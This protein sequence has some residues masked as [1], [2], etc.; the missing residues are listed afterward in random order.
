MIATEGE[1]L[2][3]SS[4]SSDS[5]LDNIYQSTYDQVNGLFMQALEASTFSPEAYKLISDSQQAIH[6]LPDIASQI[7]EKK[8]E[9]E[10]N[11]L[12]ANQFILESQDLLAKANLVL[13]NDSDA[14][15]DSVYKARFLPLIVG[16][17]LSLLFLFFAL[18]MG[19][20]FRRK[21]VQSIG[22]LL[23]ATKAVTSGKLETRA[24]I[25]EADEFG[26][27]ADS[28][29][30]MTT[31]LNE[32]TVSK[33]FVENIL[34]SMLDCVFVL[35]T[36]GTILR[37]NRM[38]SEIF[39]YSNEELLSSHVQ[40]ILGEDFRLGNSSMN[41]ETKA[42]AKSGKV[43]PIY[44][45][46]SL[47]ENQQELRVCVIKD[48][49]EQK[50]FENELR[51]RNL[52]LANSNRELEAFS[53]SVSH[54]LRSPLRGI[55]GFSQALT[56]DYADKL[57]EEAKSYLTRI[58]AGVQR[59]G[60]LIDDILNLA[61]LSRANMTVKPVDL[62]TL[63]RTV[64]SELLESDPKRE[65]DFKIQDGITANADPIL[66]RVAVENLIGNAW[67][68]T[69]KKT[70]A[71]IEFGVT[72]RNGKTAYYIKD[73]GAGFDM[74]YSEKLFVPFQRLHEVAQFPGSGV[75]LASVQ[76]VIHRHGGNI[77]AEGLVEQGATFYFTL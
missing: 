5:K 26:V 76:R 41:L 53:Y 75:G 25:L 23:G 46:L 4:E 42:I 77:W 11:L 29:N 9:A 58:R 24:P 2:K 57:D 45:S 49:T 17:T 44:I 28:F 72:D 48:I 47:L 62:S 35:S 67:K 15:F 60:H 1:I 54:D 36:D 27:L 55:D 50:R 70:S 7:L 3:A 51:D 32:S 52:A 37:V 12:I 63:V 61:R 73:N 74:T 22:S 34:E 19:M 13:S 30:T 56:E 39:G 33:A 6:Q 65:V 21:L 20:R 71:R 14:L 10:A 40:K 8:G 66:I 69:S 38:A 64:A 16:I 68:Y 31:H 43:I 59:M 18:W